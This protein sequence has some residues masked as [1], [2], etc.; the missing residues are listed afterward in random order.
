MGFNYLRY[1]LLATKSSYKRW[2]A[3]F[4]SVFSLPCSSCWLPGISRLC[5]EEWWPTAGH[6]QTAYYSYHQGTH[7]HV[8]CHHWAGARVNIK[9]AFSGW[10]ISTIKKRWL[11]DPDNLIQS[12]NGNS[13]NYYNGICRLKWVPRWD[14][15]ASNSSLLALYAMRLDS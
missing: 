2:R 5:V 11:G 1:L 13:Y 4:A 8:Y 10:R 9:T 12:Y 14:P 3:Q 7:P 15:I 6:R